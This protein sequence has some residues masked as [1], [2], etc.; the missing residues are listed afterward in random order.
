MCAQRALPDKDELLV[1]GKLRLEDLQH[2]RGEVL[3]HLGAE[4][5]LVAGG[6]RLEQL[7]S[8]RQRIRRMAAA[9]LDMQQAAERYLYLRDEARR[10]AHDVEAGEVSGGE[11]G[12]D[13]GGGD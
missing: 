13:G 1:T 10:V 9:S 5:A 3:E 11:G 2:S 4:R 12:G 7:E 8:S 6:L